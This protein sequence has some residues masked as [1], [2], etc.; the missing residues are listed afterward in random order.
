QLVEE[1]NKR[2][3]ELA[4]LGGQL[5]E[6]GRGLLA[7]MDGADERFQTLAA[8]ADEAA[9]IEKLVPT[10]VATVER[11]ERRVADVDTVV[12]SLEARAQNLE[13]LAE[14]TR[15]LG[16]ELE[17]RQAALDKA[18]EHLGAAS[19]LRQQAAAGA[20]QLEERTGQLTG[21]LATAG[22]RLTE[23]TATLDEL[24]SRAG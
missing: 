7:R 8:H 20:Q 1:L 6:R 15:T 9:R 12:A 18:S 17:L 13:G 2:L 19:Q 24:D 3:S 22:A 11:A 10:A 4:S 21:A 23:L 16:Q 5:E 14:R